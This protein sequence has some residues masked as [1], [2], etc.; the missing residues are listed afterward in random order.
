MFFENVNC[1]CMVL[2]QVVLVCLRERLNVT[3]NCI[4]SRTRQD[5][6]YLEKG[7][8]LSRKGYTKSRIVSQKCRVNNFR[9]LFP[10]T[11]EVNPLHRICSG[12]IRRLN[13]KTLQTAF[14]PLPPL[15]PVQMSLLSRHT[16]RFDRL[17][18]RHIYSK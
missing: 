3:G 9:T 4:I 13:I 12:P 6:V 14:V 15:S 1:M 16:F 7:I 2:Y 5:F 11:S 18:S 10:K 8:K 17:G